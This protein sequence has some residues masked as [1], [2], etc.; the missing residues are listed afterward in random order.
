MGQIFGGGLGPFIT[1]DEMLAPV[2]IGAFV[3]GDGPGNSPE[4][5]VLSNLAMFVGDTGEA[6]GVRVQLIAGFVTQPGTA[7]VITGA[8]TFGDGTAPVTL[9]IDAGAATQGDIEFHDAGALRWKIRHTSG[10]GFGIERYDAAGVLQDEPIGIDVGGLMT[11]PNAALVT[12]RWKFGTSDFALIGTDDDFDNECIV[13]INEVLTTSV[14]F[15]L[16]VNDATRTLTFT[17]DATLNQDVDTTASPSF[18]VMTST[19]ATGTAPFVVAST[20]AVANL[21]A[22]L[23]DGNEAT[24]FALAS[25][26]HLEADITDLQSYLLAVDIDTLAELNAIITD[27][28]LIDTGDARLSDA[29]TPLAHTHLEADITDLQSYLLAAD[30]DTL[31]ELNAIITDATLIDTGDARL[32]DARTPLSHTHLEADITDL[33]AYLLATS[34]D[35][36]AELNDIV[37]DATLIDTGDS[38]LSDSRAPNG[39]ASGDLNGTY[40]SPGV[41]DG[42]DGSA[43]HD[44]TAGEILAVPLKAVPLNI[45][46]VL[47][48][49][50]ADSNNKKRTTAQAIADLGS[51]VDLSNNFIFSYDATTQAIASGSTYQGLDFATNGEINGWTHATG[52]SIFGCTQTGKYLVEVIT[53]WEKSTGGTAELGMRA[54][55]N[56]A[57]VAGSMVGEDLVSNNVSITISKTFIVNATTAQN[58][59][60]EV[61][62]TSTNVSI[63]PSPD[64][65]GATADISASITITRIT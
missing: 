5:V 20:T 37:G 11:L 23:L 8:W 16:V 30:I 43:I 62:S 2:N 12:A 6:T 46:V 51:G 49:D 27:A 13:R 38:R 41:D 52:T 57:E 4:E 15:N 56:D 33:Q 18:V 10:S 19:Q 39:T 59:E 61:A 22:D 28:T 47:I 54:L 64:P 53:T 31:A 42:A 40:P 29:R 34:I 9:T 3:V 60:I 35:T 44:D 21:N 7:E 63:V 17:G 14:F 50:T 58:L 26:T 1:L 45:D 24:A 55:F 32:S 65:G 25:H 36:L 48:E